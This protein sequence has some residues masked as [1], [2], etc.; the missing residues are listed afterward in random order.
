MADDQ[1][2]GPYGSYFAVVNDGKPSALPEPPA[3]DADSAVI[4]LRNRLEVAEATLA[5]V[6]A[7]LDPHGTS[8]T[9]RAS[10]PEFKG[11]GL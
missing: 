6:L 4:E 7:H 8:Q 5:R 2:S 9:L 11:F 10:E 1:N 3:F